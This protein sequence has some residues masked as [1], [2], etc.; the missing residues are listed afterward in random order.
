MEW[1]GRALLGHPQLVGWLERLACA[2]EAAVDA[3]HKRTSST[4][5]ATPPAEMMSGPFRPAGYAARL[6]PWFGL[7]YVAKWRSQLELFL[8]DVTGG[9]T[10]LGYL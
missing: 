8:A 2:T 7:P 5:N 10:L 6:V 1:V 4:A 3:E 9:V